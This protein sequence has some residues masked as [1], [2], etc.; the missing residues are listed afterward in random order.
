VTAAGEGAPGGP[1]RVLL[2][3]KDPTLGDQGAGV[4]GDT[5]ARHV[6]YAPAAPERSSA[7]WSLLHA[8]EAPGPEVRR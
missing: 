7:D 6:A 1:L 5:R 2:I 4:A 3:G 8:A